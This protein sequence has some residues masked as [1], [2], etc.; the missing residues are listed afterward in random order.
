LLLLI[1]LTCAILH[2]LDKPKY[3]GSKL[4]TDINEMIDY[5]MYL[6]MEGVNKTCVPWRVL[7]PSLA[8]NL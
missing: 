2:M 8:V 3:W 7:F 4:C 6:K 1:V 5:D